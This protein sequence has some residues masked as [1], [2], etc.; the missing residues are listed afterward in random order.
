MTIL[1]PSLFWLIKLDFFH[2]ACCGLLRTLRRYHDNLFNKMA[3]KFS[4]M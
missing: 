4:Q 3:L 2:L 1:G